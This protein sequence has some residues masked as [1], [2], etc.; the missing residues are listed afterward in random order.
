MAS[1]GE[2]FGKRLGLEELMKMEPHDVIS[3]LKEEIRG[4]ACSLSLPHEDS[5]KV[6]IHKP[7]RG[8]LRRTEAAGTLILDLPEQ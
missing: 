1:G 2:D 5:E 7:G 4:P 3:A 8:L 6:A